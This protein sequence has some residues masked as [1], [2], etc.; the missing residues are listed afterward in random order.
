MGQDTRKEALLPPT[1]RGGHPGPETLAE[2]PRTGLSEPTEA[3]TT[4]PS[5]GA[6]VGG[7]GQWALMWRK[8]RK[9]R[10]AVVGGIITVLLY[11]IAIFAEFLSPHAPGR[12]FREYPYA[13]PQRIQLFLETDDGTRFRPHV[14]GWS[15]TVD[16]VS[17]SREF[18]VNQ[19]DVIPIGFFVR[20]DPYKLLGLFELEV[21]FFGPVNSDQPMFLLGADRL[22]RDLLSRI[23][24]GTRISMTIGLVGVLLSLVLGVL[25]GGLSGY[26]GG[27]ADNLIQRVIEFL[28]SIP[29]IPLWMGLA[30]AIPQS[31]PPVQV[32]FFITVILSILGWTGLARVVR[33][34]FFSLKT[35]DFVV[36]AQLD[37]CSRMRTITRHM[38]PSFMSHIIAVTT[39]SIPTMI[40]A[41]TSLSFLGLGLRPPI[42]SWGVLLQAAQN[43]RA[44]STAPW[45]LLPGVFVIIAVLGFNFLGD[46]LRDAADP[47]S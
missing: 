28:Q 30:A 10:L 39:L 24:M 16:P 31:V 1:A 37:G 40:I 17:Y 21:R 14:L 6:G 25:L 8:F 47:Y 42:V 29:K 18:E 11:V 33:G 34:K 23:L 9:H 46:G 15:A 36:A 13:P 32:Y 4:T 3:L 41:E 2:P 26:I 27:A 7:L 19:E 43:L 20:S 45:L 44:V 38:V 35:E 5:N 22:G 12:Y